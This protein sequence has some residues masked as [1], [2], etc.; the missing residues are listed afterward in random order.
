PVEIDGEAYWDGGYSSNPPLRPLIEAGA[1]PDVIL[2]HTSPL[3]RPEVPRSSG[4]IEARSAELAFGCAL[5]Q[6]LRSLAVGQRLLAEA[7]GLTP[8]LARL[9]DARLH[10]IVA[11][12]AFRGMKTHSK[13]DPTWRF[14]CG[15]RELGWETADHWLR[16]HGAALGRHGS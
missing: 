5:R 9:R 7:T 15:L 14:L 3:E 8:S 1:A 13:L 12:E 4:D 6:E 2:V 11:E 10:M 16:V